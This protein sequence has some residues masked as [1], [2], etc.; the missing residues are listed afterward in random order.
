MLSCAL[1]QV[2]F[3][4]CCMFDDTGLVIFAAAA[5]CM[6]SRVS[7][8]NEYMQQATTMD[9]V[10]D[11][12]TV[13]GAEGT[14]CAPSCLKQGRQFGCFVAIRLGRRA[15]HQLH[16]CPFRG[17]TNKGIFCSLVGCGFCNTPDFS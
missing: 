15:G 16:I 6:C 1:L 13:K 7:C 11:W 5:C 9:D 4:V 12:W 8:T 17:P 14:Q 10:M 2:A 3:K